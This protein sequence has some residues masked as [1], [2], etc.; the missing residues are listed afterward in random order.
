VN[1]ALKN[2]LS[3]LA[4]GDRYAKSVALLP[5]ADVTGYDYWPIRGIVK[6]AIRQESR[7]QG[8]V[9]YCDWDGRV[10]ERLG[11]VR[12]TSN[13]VLF[14]KDGR[15]LFVESG[16]LSASRQDELLAALRREVED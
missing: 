12:G 15:T 3:K 10:R 7:K 9:I 13:V 8:A 4:K 11:L 6:G 2:A 1:Q 16:E 14:G 5:V